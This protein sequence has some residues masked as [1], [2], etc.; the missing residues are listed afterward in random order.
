DKAIFAEGDA[1][2]AFYL[3]EKGA[4]RI[5]KMTPLGEEALAILREGAFFGEMALLDDT[6]RS[7]HAFPHEG[8]ARLIEFRVRELRELMGRDTPLACKMLWALCRTLA[9]R[10]RDTNDRFQSLFIMTSSFQ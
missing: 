3:V 7:A 5:S 6:P 1:G 8:G 10:L 9:A 4:V 2:S